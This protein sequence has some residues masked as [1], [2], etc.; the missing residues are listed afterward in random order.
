MLKTKAM[1][2]LALLTMFIAP[3]PG[4]AP[5]PSVEHMVYI[6]EQFPPFNYQEEGMLKGI[7]VDLLD[8]M[9]NRMDQDLN[10]SSIRLS[11]W[12]VG[13]QIAL[14]KNNTVIFSTARLPERES[15]FKWV[16]PI[17]PTRIVLFAMKDKAINIDSPEDLKKYRIAVIQNSAEQLLAIKAGLDPTDLVVE[18]NSNI[19]MKF[20]ED[21]TI[22]A[23]AY[24][25]IPGMWLLNRYGIKTSQYKTIFYLGDDF[26]L[27]YAFNKDIPDSLVQAFQRALNQTKQEKDL[28][29]ISDYEKILYKY[30]PTRYSTQNV[31]DEKVIR[32]VNF[33]LSCIESDAPGTFKKISA[34]EHPFKDKDD[35][36]LYVFVYDT[37]INMVAHAD[38]PQLVGMNFMGKVDVSGK[39]FGDEIVAG[40][41]RSRTGWVDYIDTNPAESGLY[42]KTTYYKLTRGS[43][44]KQY[45]VCCGKYREAQ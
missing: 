38:N 33:T 45:V 11:A 25:E 19:I 44:G 35:P 23:W 26:E 39:K 15:S 6:T 4:Y 31:T 21:G 40:A 24:A 20:L 16:G 32:L 13:Y 41:I 34:G 8:R 3:S 43:D 29:G 1:P 27:Y 42:Y 30:I 9:Q 5:A 10:R 12:D 37:E 28:D 36:A 17:S 22:D 18:N 7:S 14:E 2:I